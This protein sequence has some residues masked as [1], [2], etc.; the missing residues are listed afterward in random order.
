MPSAGKHTL[1]ALL[2]L[3]TLSALSGCMSAELVAGRLTETVLPLPTPT[4][5]AAPTIAPTQSPSL[6]LSTPV[7]SP[8]ESS[9]PAATPTAAPSDSV[10]SSATASPTPVP[11]TSP[12]HSSREEAL[13]ILGGPRLN[14]DEEIAS[15]CAEWGVQDERMGRGAAIR[16]K[17]EGNGCWSAEIWLRYGVFFV[18]YDENLRRTS[19]FYLRDEEFMGYKIGN[20]TSLEEENWEVVLLDVPREEAPEDFPL[21]AGF[22]ESD[23]G[24]TV[25]LLC[26]LSDDGEVLGGY[27]APAE[28]IAMLSETDV[29]FVDPGKGSLVVDLE[30]NTVCT[31]PVSY[32]HLTLPTILLV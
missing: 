21:I 4:A 12:K 5:E 25:N 24:D 29:T 30:T 22:D 18:R 28:W 9:S 17:D 7:P 16:M 14:E 27:V 23:F 11:T 10:Q 20:I 19:G 3:T 26:L 15:L 6:D 13:E 1:A 8:A 2:C 32:T 31:N